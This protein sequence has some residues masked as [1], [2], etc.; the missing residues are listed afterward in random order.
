MLSKKKN[1]YSTVGLLKDDR[2]EEED[3]T[4]E[5]VINN[6]TFILAFFKNRIFWF[7]EKKRK[8]E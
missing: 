7:L 1:Y 2:L 8:F 3:L 4:T 6:F 5:D